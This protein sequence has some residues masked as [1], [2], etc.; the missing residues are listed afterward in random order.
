MGHTAAVLLSSYHAMDNGTFL[1]FRAI[2]FFFFLSPVI[3]S[4]H[5]MKLPHGHANDA[6]DK[7]EIVD[8]LD[9]LFPLPSPR[10]HPTDK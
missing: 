4:Q 7:L 3:A 5:L 10:G 6:I 1:A 9:G 8:P 2:V